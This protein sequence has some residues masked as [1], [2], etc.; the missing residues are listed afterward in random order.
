MTRRRRTRYRNGFVVAL[1][2]VPVILYFTFRSPVKMV[3]AGGLAQAMMLPII[4]IGTL[5]LRHRRLPK[6]IAP[7]AVGDGLPVVRQW[8][9]HL[10]D[11][12]L[13]D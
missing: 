10:A 8:R 13:R 12:L 2:V 6:E 1:T 3:V 7:R 5:Y 11:W 9:D 4:A